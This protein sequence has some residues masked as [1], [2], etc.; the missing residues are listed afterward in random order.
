MKFEN[1]IY[2]YLLFLLPVIAILFYGYVIWRTKTIKKL[3]DEQLIT[4][5]MPQTSVRRKWVKLII[6][7]VG[8]GGL[9]IGL[10]NLRMGSKKE[11][12]TGESA[13][14]IICFDISNSMLAED[15]KPNRLTQAKITASQLIQKLAP[16]KIGLIVFAGESF[17]QMPLTSD[18][19][20]ALMY[21]NT[22]NT[23][24]ISAQG[25]AIG[26]TIETALREF[27]SGGENKS[28]KGKAIIII[29]D[30]ESHD[31]NALE[32]AKEAAN[33]NIKIIALGVGTPTGG[34]IPLKKGN[35]TEAFKKDKDGNIVLT[36]LNEQ[37]MKELATESNGVYYN[38][39]E[40]KKV[41]QKVHDE[42]DALDKTKD[43]AYEYTAYANHF[44]IFLAFGLLLITIEFFMSD[45]KPLWLEKIKLFDA[46][47]TN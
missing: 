10:A 5:L 41:I 29:T 42:I 4:Q 40:G 45:R 3:G 25:T 28:K 44:Q 19:R 18:T 47:K 36:K 21:L 16:N 15:V 20:A 33:K 38:V 2:L 12:I 8:L 35:N 27:E 31:E 23:D 11:K 46:K 13:E 43:D 1:I 39:A 9:I 17:V 24:L 32:M 7:L 26:K 37:I 34:P 14:V 22:I 30:G 6:M